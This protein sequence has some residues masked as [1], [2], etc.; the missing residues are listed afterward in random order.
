LRRYHGSTSL[1][2]DANVVGVEIWR[3]NTLCIQRKSI[4]VVVKSVSDMR[5]EPKS[6]LFNERA[7]IDEMLFQENATRFEK[8]VGER[9]L[10]RGRKRESCSKRSV[11][12]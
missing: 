5:R 9:Q 12:T 3:I 10:N 1:S 6:W 7:R 2:V 4:H 11:S 8:L